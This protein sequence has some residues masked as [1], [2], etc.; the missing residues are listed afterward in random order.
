TNIPDMVKAAISDLDQFEIAG[1]ERQV[2]VEYYQWFLLPGIVMLIA[3][4]VAGTR[5]RGLGP[6]SAAAATAFA[7]LAMTPPARA[8]LERDAR[9]AL[10][11]GEHERA[12]DLYK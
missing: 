10:E 4:I 5:W 3:S 6:A 11:A 1:R 12:R 8:D 2:A 7:L 9:S